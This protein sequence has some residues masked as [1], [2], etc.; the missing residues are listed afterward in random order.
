M[1]KRLNKHF[2]KEDM[3]MANRYMK[4]SSKSLIFREIK[5]KT[6]MRYRFALGR[7]AIIEKQKIRSVVKDVEELEP[8]YTVGGNVKCYSHYGK[9]C[10]GALKN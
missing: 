4:K 2:S 5:I 9:H 8:L 1:G 6:T 10:G 3:Q 7:M